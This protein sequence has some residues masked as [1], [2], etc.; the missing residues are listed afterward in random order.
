M[1]MICR[2]IPRHDDADTLRMRINQ[3]KKENQAENIY[4]KYASPDKRKK[5][6]GDRNTRTTNTKEIRETR[7]KLPEREREKRREE[8]RDQ[9]EEI[10]T[11]ESSMQ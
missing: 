3:T 6:N 5:N 4:E 2:S 10:S 11:A 7:K 8:R 1:I 9:K